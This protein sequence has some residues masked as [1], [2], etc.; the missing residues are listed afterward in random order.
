[1]DKITP[2]DR[3]I[4]KELCLCRVLTLNLDTHIHTNTHI[5]IHVYMY[6]SGRETITFPEISGLR[7][8]LFVKRF[9]R[10]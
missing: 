5:H 10:F 2:K 1:M 6:F 7:V 8:A 3:I 9:F 4:Y